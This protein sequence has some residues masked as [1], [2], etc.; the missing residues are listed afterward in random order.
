[1]APRTAGP[2]L[3][4][5]LVICAGVG[6][7]QTDAAPTSIRLMTLDPGHFHAGLVHRESYPGVSPRVDVY[8]PLGP[9][10]LAH[11]KRVVGFNSRP[12]SPTDWRVDVHTGPDFFERLRKEKPGNVVVISGRNRGKIDYVQG[13]VQA[14]LSALVDKPWILDSSDFGK[15]RE[16]LDSADER[17]LVALD[18][19]TERFEVTSLLQK[20][21]VGD[22]AIFGAAVSG[23]PH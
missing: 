20:E 11:L 9:D 7:A 3:G 15:L 18:M 23:T 19:M 8:A 14:G 13:S 10:L 16:T 4:V 6:F 21:M 22:P 1:M 5:L 17:G 12:Q 2:V